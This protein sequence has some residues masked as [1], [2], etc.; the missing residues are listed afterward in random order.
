MKIEYDTPTQHGF[1]HDGILLVLLANLAVSM[2]IYQPDTTRVLLW[3]ALLA[4]V[5]GGVLYLFSPLLAP[6]T[7]AR[8]RRR[9]LALKSSAKGAQEVLEGLVAKFPEAK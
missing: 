5:A 6:W 8:R 9:K 4:V 7:D 2:Q 3:A 1:Q